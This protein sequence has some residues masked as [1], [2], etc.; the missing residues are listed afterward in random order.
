MKS[1]FKYIA[2]GAV[3]VLLLTGTTGCEDF[4]KMNTNPNA[5]TP[6]K[7]N[8]LY[9]LPYVQIY[10][11]LNVDQWERIQH[12]TVDMF[13]QY[14]ANCAWET[15]LCQTNN[16]WSTG[17]WNLHWTWIANLNHIIRRCE[18]T[19]ENNNLQQISRI[20]R[21]WCF[22]RA[23]DLFGDMPYS[24]AC[25]GLVQAASYDSQKDIYY[26]LFKELTEA[27]AAL[28]LSKNTVNDY[29]LIF[30]G[31]AASWQRFANSL[32]LRLAM[33]LTECDP[34]KAK[35]EAEAAINAPGGLIKDNVQIWR[36]QNHYNAINPQYPCSYYWR[37]HCCMSVSMQRIL[38]NL[39][40]VPVKKLSYYKEGSYPH[41]A[42]PRGIIMY[43]VTSQGTLAT[44]EFRGRWKGVES[45]Y[46]GSN[47]SLPNNARNNNS[48]IG[49]FFCSLDP[50][51]PEKKELV[52]NYDRMFNLMY[53]AEIDFLRAEGAIRGWKMGGNAKDF[54]EAGIRSKMAEYGN[55]IAASDIET[56]LGSDM[57]NNY[58]TSVKWEDN[59]GVLTEDCNSQLAKII[60]QKY[61]ANYPENS[62]E[63]WNDYRRLGMPALDPFMQPTENYVVEVHGYD[64]RGSVR[65]LPWP[66]NEALEN[67]ENYE[68]AVAAFGKPDE[69]KSRIWWDARQSVVHWEY[70]IDPR[71]Q[72]IGTLKDAIDPRTWKD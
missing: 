52:I 14:F 50:T 8:P 32:R 2:M 35:A 41:F 46:A 55:L 59:T 31:D 39:G 7:V 70:Y 33:R 53:V 5:M 28:D 71:G 48:R 44:R 38:T 36:A 4:D 25:N 23:T 56:Y 24:E 12:L 45:G 37:S 10:S 29:D 40:G 16:G 51:P 69:S 20:W 18:E 60:T 49:A 68:A 1:F 13:S 9:H 3:G 63:A 57:K 54:Y 72:E 61:I 42:D 62:F 17:F 26:D 67:T 15:Q 58:G 11:T 34:G 66:Q 64:W 47:V 65:R 6:E 21:A 22:S 43:N 30:A 27:G 19:G